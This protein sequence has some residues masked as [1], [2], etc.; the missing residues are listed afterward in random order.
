MDK[1]K[2]KIDKNTT[3]LALNV[4]LVVLGIIG[5]I[6]TITGL[7]YPAWEYYTQLSNYFA[8]ISAAI[9]VVF[10]IR[11]IKDKSKEIPKWVSILKYTSTLS[12]LVTFLVVVFILKLYYDTDIIIWILFDG[13]NLFYH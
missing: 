13:Y 8:L 9:Y 6:R 11:N 10:L 3:A 1:T 5:F 2:I 7:G 12:L 4:V